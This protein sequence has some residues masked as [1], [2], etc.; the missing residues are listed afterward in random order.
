MWIE[1]TRDGE[2]TIKMEGFTGTDC[3]E[4]SKNVEKALGKVDKREDTLEMYQE[5]EN[6]GTLTNG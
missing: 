6:V 2:V 5:A 1:I 4:A 3:L